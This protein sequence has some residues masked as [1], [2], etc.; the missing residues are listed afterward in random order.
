[1]IPTTVEAWRNAALLGGIVAVLAM[2]G[3]IRAARAWFPAL[4]LAGVG[5]AFWLEALAGSWLLSSLRADAP[6]GSALLLAMWAVH[7][8]SRWLRARSWP[9]VV[10]AAALLGDRFVAMGLALCEPDPAR[11]ARLVVAAS[12]ASLVG[13]T[14]GAAPLVLGWGGL[15]CVGVGL[16][17]AALGYSGAGDFGRVAPDTRAAVA[18]AVVPVFGAV[19]TWLAIVGGALEVLADGLEGIPLLAMPRGDL[20]VYGGAV[21]AGAF[22]DEGLFALLA[23]ETELRALSLRGDAIPTSLRAGLAVGGGLPLLV[24]TG[25]RLRVGVPLWLAQV[26]VVTAWLYL[27]SS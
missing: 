23:R 14:S 3:Q 5:A 17:L 15:E 18:A 10:L 8:D 4:V 11:R 21:L 24:L 22:G 6:W 26:G 9:A 19:V 2:V 12:G 16:V 20:L 1:M 13:W 27:R 7:G 25:S